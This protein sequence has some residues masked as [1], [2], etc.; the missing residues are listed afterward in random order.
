MSSP[1]TS[2][3]ARRLAP[4]ATLAFASRADSDD[5]WLHASADAVAPLDWRRWASGDGGG[6][7][8]H[9]HLPP[10][11]PP[12]ERVA[13]SCFYTVLLF[14]RMADR[15]HTR[16]R[17][18]A[19][20]FSSVCVCESH[21]NTRTRTHS[22]WPPA[23]YALWPQWTRENFSCLFT[24][25]S[26]CRTHAHTT[27]ASALSIGHPCDSANA[28]ARGCVHSHQRT[29]ERR[30]A[31]VPSVERNS[32]PL[33]MVRP[34]MRCP[35]SKITTIAALIHC[36]AQLAHSRTHTR[37]SCA[38]V[39]AAHTHTFACA[40]PFAAISGCARG[41][42]K[43]NQKTGQPIKSVFSI[44]TQS[45]PAHWIDVTRRMNCITHCKRH[46]DNNNKRASA[47]R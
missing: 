11:P 4:A 1:S 44:A 6:G 41:T 47:H 20:S 27:C 22:Q 10:P 43:S 29:S 26:L 17:A 45:R 3:G 33:P 18:N 32:L 12:H 15:P 16:A 21:T 7:S 28:R 31:A 25:L 40:G 35:L 46:Q 39:E 2:N 9:R 37:Q 13:C 23:N 34:L 5:V 19:S 24:S 8:V 42:Q 38:L 14:V 30:H 36:Y